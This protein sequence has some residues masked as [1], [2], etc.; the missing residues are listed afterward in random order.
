MRRH[1]S[2]R[3][4]HQGPSRVNVWWT[5]KQR[6]F[7][8]QVRPYFTEVLLGAPL[9]AACGRGCVMAWFSV[10]IVFIEFARTKVFQ[11]PLSESTQAVFVAWR[12]TWRTRWGVYKRIYASN[13]E[14]VYVLL[15]CWRSGGHPTE[16]TCWERCN[17]QVLFSILY[18]ISSIIFLMLLVRCLVNSIV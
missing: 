16:S 10:N 14:I 11:F 13:W 6:S 3:L 7:P 12:I 4:P 8:K 17:L 2:L 5:V 15:T 18:P 9:Q 1:I